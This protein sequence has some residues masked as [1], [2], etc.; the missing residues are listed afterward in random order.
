[1]MFLALSALAAC[2]AVNPFSDRIW[3]H[4]F[5]A[6]WPALA[7]LPRDTEVGFAPAPGFQRVFSL[8]E[9]RLLAARFHESSVPETPVCFERRLTP[10]SSAMLLDAM[11]RELPGARMEIVDFGPAT[12]PQG[13]LEF[14]LSGL[15]PAP[16]GAIWNGA[17]RYAGN[18]RFPLWARVKLSVTSKRVIARK[19]FQ[20]G[21]VLDRAGL[22]E[23]MRTEFPA[24]G[25]ASS[26]EE[27]AGKAVRRS[28]AAGEAIRTRWLEP[29]K[30]VLRGDLVR[31]EVQRGGAHLRLDGRAEASGAAGE[32]IPVLNPVTHRT[33]RAR[34]QGPGRVFVEAGKS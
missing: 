24:S 33:F 34:V 21:E 29:P 6:A 5:G 2:L 26:I 30:L 13:L 7:S 28:V 19:L 25:F 14:P 10:L 23:E 16:G 31:V 8:G 15:H 32:V 22:A 4:D 1:M 12:V 20:P 3:A 17:V 11:Q 9:L 18:H 27:V